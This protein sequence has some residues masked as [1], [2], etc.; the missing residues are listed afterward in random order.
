MDAADRRAAPRAIVAQSG[1]QR[2]LRTL[3]AL[4]KR[5]VLGRKRILTSDEAKIARKIGGKVRKATSYHCG[6]WADYFRNWP[7]LARTTAAKVRWWGRSTATSPAG[8]A[9]ITCRQLGY[10]PILLYG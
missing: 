6:Q 7:Y 1:P 4:T 10:L 2:L 3:A 5:T 8:R 9:Y